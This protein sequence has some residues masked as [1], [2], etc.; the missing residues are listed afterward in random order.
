ML[1]PDLLNPGDTTRCRIVTAPD[2][3]ATVLVDLNDKRAVALD[4]GRALTLGAPR[5]LPG[6]GTS[7]DA[8]PRVVKLP[9]KIY[10]DQGRA[11]ATIVAIARELLSTQ[12]RYILWQQNRTATPMWLKVRPRSTSGELDLSMVP[13]P[14]DA[15]RGGG[16]SKWRLR[17]SRTVPASPKR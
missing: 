8:E 10:G 16:T 5:L 2:E 6:A 15:Q 4:R 14:G 7:I 17:R 1:H 13:L 11:E 3:A 9:L 12:A